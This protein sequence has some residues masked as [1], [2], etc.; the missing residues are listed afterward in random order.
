MNTDTQH[1]TDILIVGGGVP[2]LCL[3]T[4]LGQHDIPCIILDT[5]ICKPA[6]ETTPHNKTVAIMEQ[7]LQTLK[8][9][10]ILPDLK[11]YIEALRTMRIIDDSDPARD[12][13]QIDFHAEDSGLDAF[14]YNIPEAMLRS[15]LLDKVKACASVTY[16]A[17]KKLKDFETDNTHITATLECGEI[18]QTKLIIG[19]DGRNSQ[20]RKSANITAKTFD[21]KQS[22]M[23][24]CID[25]SLPHHNIS[26]EF[27]RPGGPF[28]TV[29]LPGNTSSIVWVEKTSDA[30]QMIALDKESFHAAVQDRTNGILGTIEKVSAPSLWPLM[31]LT[32]KSFHAK[33]CA[34]VAEAAHVM[35][36]IG[37]QGLNLSLRDISD[38]FMVLKD[39]Y[40]C[41]GDPGSESTL[42]RYESL[43][44]PDIHL[45]TNAIHSMNMLVANDSIPLRKLRRAGIL[46]I[47]N[48]PPLK[49]LL[50]QRGR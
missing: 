50:T 25:H 47:D 49:Q 7:S 41:G 3:A 37:A 6:Q 45:R 42:S 35:S 10:N 12:P 8:P 4:L 46:A 33:R 34:L 23:T 16:L 36:P 9:L 32:A 21:Y 48:L 40:Y 11:P 22:A 29:P 15:A 28:T 30:E 39:T 1:S 20:T 13:T 44:R 24:F 27:H 19:A 14:G 43:R 17:P 26:S 5:D 18:I 31:R 38:L 2:G